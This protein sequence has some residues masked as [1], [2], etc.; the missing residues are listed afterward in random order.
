MAGKFCK[1]RLDGLSALFHLHE[2]SMLILCI[3]SLVF[4]VVAAVG[5]LLV[6]R[7]LWKASSIPVNLKKLF[8]SLAFSDLAVGMFVQPMFGVILATMLRQA[9]TGNYNFVSLCP[10]ILTAC[11]YFMFLLGCA[12]FFNITAIALDRLLAISLHLR[13]L[14]L[15][16]EKRVLKGLVSIWATSAVIASIFIALPEDNNL[17][18]AAID[19]VG[20]LLTSVAYVR[21]Y[22]IVRYHQNQIQCIQIQ[23]QNT[24]TT[25]LLRQKKSAFNALFVYVVFLICYLPLIFSVVLDTLT[26]VSPIPVLMA[27]NFTE[28]LVLLN[29]SLNPF[30]LCWRYREIR[31]IVTSIVMK[32]LRMKIQLTKGDNSSRRGI[33]VTPTASKIQ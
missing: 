6:I 26:N 5:N 29:S 25:E 22:K 3:L 33:D 24:Q 14:E 27:H 31:Q 1:A 2:S 12:S 15:I 7:A 20:L 28:F 13:Y 19:F 17:V 8:F 11:Y 23:L 9:S 32:K 16:T 10:N 4:A 21:I 30:I 18:Q